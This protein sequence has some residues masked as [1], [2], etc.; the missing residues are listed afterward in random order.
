M[1][2][3]APADPRDRW[4]AIAAAVAVNAGLG[5][6]IVTGLNVQI[7]TRAVETLKT[8]NLAPPPPPPP[9]PPPPPRPSPR[10]EMKKPAGAPAK[11]TEPTPV[12]A[13]PPRIPAPSPIPAARVAGTGS[14]ATSG[15]GTSGTGTGAGGSGYGPGGGGAGAY[16]PA[17]Q[18]TTIPNREYRQLS[19]TSGMVAGQV[20]VA[21]RI[22]PNGTPSNC[23]VVR[24]SG[25]PPADSLMCV[26][27]SQYVR[28]RPA[29][30]PAGR[31]VASDITWYPRWWRP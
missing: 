25:S 12:V 8:F 14:A 19:A 24:S 16:T 6:I 26:L 20:G 11:R 27:I 1:S 22:N 10:P 4:K 29:L 31:P 15:A 7:V 30:D 18:I 2:S 3:Y 9:V 5:A 21:I 17:R 13:P 23:R 28:F